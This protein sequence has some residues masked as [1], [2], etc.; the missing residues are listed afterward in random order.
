MRYF[1]IYYQY[2]ENID[3]SYERNSH[4]STTY[5]GSILKESDSYPSYNESVKLVED[6]LDL[7]SVYNDS[8]S[9]EYTTIVNSVVEISKEDFDKLNS[10]E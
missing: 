6:Y 8:F 7:K 4:S 3:Y 2:I 10:V 5:G 1:V 9:R